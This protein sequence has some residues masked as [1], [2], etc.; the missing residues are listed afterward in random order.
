MAEL[1]ALDPAEQM[2][3]RAV[4]RAD[5][6]GIDVRVLGLP[7]ERIPLGDGEIDTVVMTFTLCSVSDPDAVV[8]ELARVLRPEGEL[9]FA[10]HGR[11]PDEGVRRWQRR[12]DPI[13]RR[14]AGG[15]HLSRD[16]PALLGAGFTPGTLEERYLPGPKVQ[17]YFYS[18]TATPTSGTKTA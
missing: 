9:I 11:A 14:V 8:G 13:Q 7:A 3:A 15:C 12:L 4:R 17:T 2:H 6:A 10:E 16:I 5:D 18:G 1:V